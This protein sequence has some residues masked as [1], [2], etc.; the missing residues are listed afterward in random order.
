MMMMIMIINFFYL[1][2][3]LIQTCT[4]HYFTYIYIIII[5]NTSI[6]IIFSDLN[7]KIFS[8]VEEPSRISTTYLIWP[9][10]HI[11]YQWL[12]LYVI[13]CTEVV[14]STKW[15]KLGWVT[16]YLFYLGMQGNSCFIAKNVLYIYICGFE[17]TIFKVLRERFSMNI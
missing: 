6:A 3:D 7:E 1:P 9:P 14:E 13:K 12:N 10:P 8:D 5:Y 16:Q 17:Q 11:I 15:S 2:L 4:S